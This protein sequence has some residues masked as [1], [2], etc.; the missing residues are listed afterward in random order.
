MRTFKLMTGL[1]GGATLLS[2]ALMP[3][4]ALAAGPGTASNNLT[5]VSSGYVADST[6]MRK[7]YRMHNLRLCPVN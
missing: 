4:A 7:R 2:L 3:L 6:V 5:T 1:S